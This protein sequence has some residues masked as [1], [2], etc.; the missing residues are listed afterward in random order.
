[1][2]LS[3]KLDEIRAISGDKKR[4][5][6]QRLFACFVVLDLIKKLSDEKAR[7]AKAQ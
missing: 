6:E 4:P 3:K 7:S 5:V 1:L 2:D